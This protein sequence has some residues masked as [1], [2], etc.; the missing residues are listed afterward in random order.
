MKYKITLA[1]NGEEYNGEGET[2]SEAIDATGLHFTDVKTKG[3]ITIKDGKYEIQKFFLAR[4]IKKLFNSSLV[5]KFW[6]NDME[7]MF[8][9]MKEKKLF[10]KEIGL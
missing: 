10:K 8:K 1:I 2:I 6:P 5:R 7:K 3:T 9:I 4:Q